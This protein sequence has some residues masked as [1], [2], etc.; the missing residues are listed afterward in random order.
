[1]IEANASMLVVDADARATARPSLAR[2]VL[3][4]FER[5]R[6]RQALA[7][8]DQRQLADIGVSREAAVREAAK[9]FRF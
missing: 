8:L 2:R 9:P 5:Q 1:M 3:S 6:Q 7:L 4:A